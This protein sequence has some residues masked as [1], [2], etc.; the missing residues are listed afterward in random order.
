MQLKWRHY[1]VSHIDIGHHSVN[2]C[3]ITRVYVHNGATS[4]T[5]NYFQRLMNMAH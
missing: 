4:Q 5:A 3:P 1:M 2:T